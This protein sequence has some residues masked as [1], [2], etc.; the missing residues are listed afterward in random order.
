MDTRLQAVVVR[1][2][3]PIGESYLQSRDELIERIRSSGYR[4]ALVVL[5]GPGFGTEAFQIHDH[6]SYLAVHMPAGVKMAAVMKSRSEDAEAR[7]FAE[8]VSNNRGLN[9]MTFDDETKA[10]AWLDLGPRRPGA[11]DKGGADAVTADDVDD[12]R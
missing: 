12:R 1:H 9:L 8:I 7:G 10:V 6:I 11:V 5:D 4:R 2:S 3:H